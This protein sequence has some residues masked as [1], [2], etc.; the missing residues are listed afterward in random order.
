MN[1]H[2]SGVDP[3]VLYIHP[4]GHESPE[5]LPAGVIAA[6]NL[7]PD[8][9]LGRYGEEVTRA[10][11]RDARVIL[12]DVHWF[13]PLGILGDLVREIRR[14]NH[15]VDVVVG[16]ITAAFYAPLIL[17]RYPID[18][19]MTGDVEVSFA[20][21]IEHLLAGERP[22]P[23]PNVWQR[24][25][26]PPV[27]ERVAPSVFNTLD[28]LTIDWFPRHW[29]RVRRYHEAY[30]ARAL[31]DLAFD[32]FAYQNTWHPILPLVRGCIRSCDHCYASYHDVVFGSGLRVR[33]PEAL[34]RD[35]GRLEERGGL[36]FINLYFAD[37]R[38]LDIYAPTL[39]EKT[40]RLDAL[41]WFCGNAD[42]SSLDQVRS[43]FKGHVSV[44]L[45]R[46]EDLAPHRSDPGPRA[47]QDQ[48]SSMLKRLGAMSETSTVAFYLGAAP[49]V[50]ARA[51][52]EEGASVRYRSGQDWR[53]RIPSVLELGPSYTLDD[54]FLDIGRQSRRAVGA[55]LLRTLVPPLGRALGRCFDIDVS[56]EE[57]R[58][59]GFDEVER[60]LIA[61][62]IRQLV[63]HGHYGFDE[64]ELAWFV[65]PL[66]GPRGARWKRPGGVRAT[67]GECQWRA[68]LNGVAWEGRL[69]VEE[70]VALE[71]ALV[72]TVWVEGEA[73]LKLGSWARA[74]VP[75]MTIPAGRRRMIRAG[76][77]RGRG[78]LVLWFVDEASDEP[79]RFAL[80][81]RPP[82]GRSSGGA[83]GPGGQLSPELLRAIASGSDS[84]EVKQALRR[85]G[86]RLRRS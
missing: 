32:R 21:L 22:P 44:N 35:L 78:R 15:E 67:R 54:Q 75:A 36:S 23:L 84:D 4:W 34:A 13:F 72:P 62:H 55:H 49:D 52:L 63:D 33:S 1:R 53:V 71:I 42:A 43:G 18:F 24:G 64:V 59:R 46:P 83:A 27:R 40:S 51:D 60:R 16:G 9:A 86:A 57:W 39:G 79:Q 58:A 50:S 70:G 20:R 69:E 74:Q 31:E 7:L 19:V 66:P 26:P 3:R 38:F 37:G 80:A 56:D 81:L 2:P 14:I 48:F 8:K 85:H 82:R 45:V 6:I 5:V 12:I 68:G 65:A 47:R 77:E 41:L 10:E 25:A 73:P 76:G 11:I 61:L 30:R 17:S 28:W 29:E